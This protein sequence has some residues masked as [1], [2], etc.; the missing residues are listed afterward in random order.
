MTYPKRIVNQ[1]LTKRQFVSQTLWAWLKLELAKVS[2][3]IDELALPRLIIAGF[4]A[5]N[6]HLPNIRRL[7]VVKT[8]IRL[9][10]L[11]CPRGSN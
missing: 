8:A 4:T 5:V 10:L 2:T 6:L 7:S 3:L 1:S 11:A 9:I